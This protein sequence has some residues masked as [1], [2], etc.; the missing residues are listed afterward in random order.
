MYKIIIADDHPITLLGTEAFLKNLNHHIVGCYP[1]GTSCFNAIVSQLPDLAVIDVSMPGMSGLE[2]LKN[3]KAK[4]LPTKIILLT[5]HHELSVFYKAKEYQ[6]D[7]YV[8]KDNAQNEL[9][10]CIQTV[11]K[12]GQFVSALLES[13]LLIDDN[14]EGSEM[15]NL[16]TQ[17]EKKVLELVAQH[18]T[19]KDIGI[20]LFITEKTVESHKRNIVEKLNLPKGKNILLQW[21]L[22][23]LK[24]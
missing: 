6:Y 22:K 7:G 4:K 20:Y 13:T 9:E 24:T 3:V 11:M 2:V 8:L 12:N 5:M 15:L 1:T 17:T 18:K 14:P 10:Q 21:A 19:N 16:L 23:N